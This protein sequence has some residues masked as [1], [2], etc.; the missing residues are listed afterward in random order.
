MKSSFCQCINFTLFSQNN[1]L[2][3]DVDVS[4]QVKTLIGKAEKTEESSKKWLSM[5]ER[6]C[7]RFCKLMVCFLHSL[8]IHRHKT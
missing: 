5:I 2:L 8:Y 3:M 7:N 4:C 6:D 1:L